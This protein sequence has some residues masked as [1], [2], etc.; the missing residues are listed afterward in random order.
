M[1]TQRDFCS[2]L[3]AAELA[4]RIRTYWLENGRHEIEVSIEKVVS[5]PKRE[6]AVYGI[7]SNIGADWQPA[8][9][10]QAKRAA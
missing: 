6:R 3:G 4:A 1:R 8:A 10:E 2:E 9:D 5:A 7:R